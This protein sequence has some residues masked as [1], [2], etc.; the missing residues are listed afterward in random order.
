MTK[1][2]KRL[3]QRQGK[4]AESMKAMGPLLSNAK[5]LLTGFDES[6]LKGIQDTLKSL[7]QKK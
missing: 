6:Q 7:K 5:E 2:T 4:L 1:D 3:I